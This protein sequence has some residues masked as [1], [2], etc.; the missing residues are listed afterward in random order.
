MEKQNI[1]NKKS[2]QTREQFVQE[3]RK[4]AGIINVNPRQ[5]RVQK[6]TRKWA[7]CSSKKWVS[8]NVDLLDMPKNFQKFVIIHELLHL[9]I[10]NHGKLFK[11]MMNIYLPGWEKQYKNLNFNRIRMSR[12]C[13]K[14]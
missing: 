13:P 10:P 11:S 8:F 2:I 6:M 3:V 14:K 4:W 7:S 5:I 12:I 9:Q 1:I